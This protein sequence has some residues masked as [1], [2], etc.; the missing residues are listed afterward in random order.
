MDGNKEI[1]LCMILIFSILKKLS[2]LTYM[3]NLKT[4]FDKILDIAKSTLSDLSLPE[5][6]FEPYRNK[7]KMTD[8]EVVALAIT[9]ESLGIDSENLLF[10]KL[11]KEYLADFPRLTDR[12]NYNRRRKRLQDYIAWVAQPVADI[13]APGNKQFILDSVP[14]PIC[15]N[16]RIYRSSICRD[17]PEMLPQRG[18]HASHKMHYY[19]FKMQ[20]VVSQV[21]VPVSIGLTPAN[22]HDVHYLDH[23][24]RNQL[25]DCELIADKGYLSAGH[26]ASLFEQDRIRLI[27]PLRVNMKRRE[28]LWN[29]AYRYTRKRIETLFSQL[30]DQL[31]LKRNYAKT[32]DGLFARMCTKISSV[33]VLQ[34]INF[35]NNKPINHLKHALAN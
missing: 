17:D 15:Q 4:N 25:H 18:Y 31:F 9:A 1:K 13:I 3:H 27:T 11:R 8:I 16:P 34:Y 5:G 7:P 24:D 6:N 19:G 2:T 22:I 28:S 12:S 20:L 23:L 30:C 32:L 14:V 10:S 26:Q 35:L 29:P 33:A 21:G